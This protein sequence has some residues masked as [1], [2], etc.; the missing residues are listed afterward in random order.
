MVDLDVEMGRC[1]AMVVKYDSHEEYVYG[2]VM[3]M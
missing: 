3:R 2:I 1:A